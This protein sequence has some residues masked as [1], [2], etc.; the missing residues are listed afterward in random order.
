V[1]LPQRRHALR[2]IVR[3]PEFGKR[4]PH[5][6]FGRSAAHNQFPVTF[7]QMLREL[8]NDFGLPRR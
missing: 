3:A 2:E 8:F 7:L 5:S 4:Q 1:G 6:L